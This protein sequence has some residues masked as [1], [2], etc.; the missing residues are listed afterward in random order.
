MNSIRRRLSLTLAL[1]LLAA[2]VLLAFALRDFPRR[3]VEEHV[4]AR[5]DHDADLLY[6]HLLDAL[7]RAD[8]EAGMD[9]ALMGAAGPAYDLPLS[10]HYFLVRL[11]G[12]QWRSRSTWDADLD[13]P[14]GLERLVSERLAGPAGQTLLVLAKRFPDSAD[15]RVVSIA[16]AEDVAAIDAAIAAFRAQALTVLGLALLVLLVLQRRVLLRGLAPLDEAVDACRRLE[17]GEAVQF[18]VDA[19]VEVRP[20]LAAVE[21]LSRHQAQRLGR[22]RHA[23]G[24]LSHALKTPL[25]VLGQGADVLAA[26]GDEE[27]AAAIRTQLE[28]MRATI[29]RELRRARLAGGGAGGAGFALRVQLGALIEVLQRL[30]AGRGLRI[31]LEADE[32]TWPVDREDMLELFGNLLDNACK[33]ARTRVR[34][35]VVPDPETARLAFSVEDDGPGV[36]PELLDRLG[37]AGLRADESRPGHGLGLAIVGDIVAQYGGTIRFGRGSALGGLRAEVELPLLG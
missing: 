5:L 17:R 9:S 18:E 36:A 14:D 16:L 31:E 27:G 19:P 1:V 22:I 26:R 33:W 2:G 4:L 23:A 6:V 13:L 28:S 11:G 8:G 21:R 29:E 24:N 15:G 10:G 37:T 35:A 25:A 7:A 3:M 34:V 12:R 30:H 20:L 32:R